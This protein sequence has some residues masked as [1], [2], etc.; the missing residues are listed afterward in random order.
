MEKINAVVEK[1]AGRMNIN[2]MN[3]GNQS[4]QIED[5]KEIGISLVLDK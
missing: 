5:L 2:V 4:S 3:T 1:L